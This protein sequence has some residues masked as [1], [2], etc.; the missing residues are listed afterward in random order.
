MTVL[1]RRVWPGMEE[2]EAAFPLFLD[3]RQYDMIGRGEGEDGPLETP[4]RRRALRMDD[5]P[6]FGIPAMRME[7]LSSGPSSSRSAISVLS[8]SGNI[9]HV[10]DETYE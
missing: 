9:L 4:T 3:F 1:S 6:T 7:I 8:A 10:L 2:V 5:F